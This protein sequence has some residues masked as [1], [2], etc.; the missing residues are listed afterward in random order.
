MKIPNSWL[1]MG[2]IL[3]HEIVSDKQ[4]NLIQH[5]K[6]ITKEIHYHKSLN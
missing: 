1:V 6:M 4:K 3:G 2:I 5:I